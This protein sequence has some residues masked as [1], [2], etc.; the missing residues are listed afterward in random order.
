WSKCM[1]RVKDHDEKLVSN[2]KEDMDNLLVFA[3]LLS[4]VL[5]AFIME[6]FKLLQQDTG[7][8]GNELLLQISQ[9]VSSFRINNGYI[10]STLL[11]SV[12]PGAPFD[13]PAEAIVINVMWFASLV[14]SLSAASVAIIIKQWLHQYADWPL[15]SPRDSLQLRQLRWMGLSKWGFR[16]FIDSLSLLL[17]AALGLFF[18]GLLVF[19]WTLN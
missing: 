9:Q 18:V 11:S 6:A 3:G 16:R 8:V 7:A 10:N 17:E 15:D 19:V 14:C 5:A 4:A 12:A 13:P 1:Q 2:W